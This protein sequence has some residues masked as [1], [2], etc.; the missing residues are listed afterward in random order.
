MVIDGKSCWAGR[1]SLVYEDQNATAFTSL[2]DRV[3]A[4]KLPLLGDVIDLVP[5]KYNILLNLIGSPTS[6]PVITYT[7]TYSYVKVI[8]RWRLV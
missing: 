5:G 1:K 3:V 4:E 6:D 2:A 7:L 8:P